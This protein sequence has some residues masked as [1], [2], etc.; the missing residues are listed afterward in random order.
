MDNCDSF[1]KS[2]LASLGIQFLFSIILPNARSW[3][4]SLQ[5]LE[6]SFF[7]YFAGKS[8]CRADFSR[9]RNLP[10][11][12]TA[13]RV[14]GVYVKSM[15][16]SQHLC[17]ACIISILGRKQRYFCWHTHIPTSDNA[18]RLTHWRYHHNAEI[19]FPLF[20]KRP[21]LHRSFR[22]FVRIASRHGKGTFKQIGPLR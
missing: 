2:T 15:P 7:A 9:I 6:E 17:Y 20:R 4:C 5:L 18:K 3:A 22:R 8:H 12:W 21:L 10:N 14:K 16:R 19:L 1:E 13:T 11:S